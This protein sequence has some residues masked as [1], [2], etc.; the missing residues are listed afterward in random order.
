MGWSCGQKAGQT[1]DRISQ[2]CRAQ[3]GSSNVFTVKGK[4]YMFETSRVEHSDGAITGQVLR[5][6]DERYVRPSGSFRIE[7]DGTISRGPAFFKQA[8]RAL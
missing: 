7:G 3:G 2:A 4:K 8:L 6:L 5:F 1:M